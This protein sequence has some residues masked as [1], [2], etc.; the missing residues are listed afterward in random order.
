MIP[1]INTHQL[2]LR[3]F[4]PADAAPL[5]RIYRQEGV[6]R[7]FPNPE[8]PPLERV[9]RF[10]QA[11]A[12]H[13]EE[14]GYGNWAVVPRGQAEIA[15]WAGLWFISETGETEV[16]YLLGRDY[17]GKGYA[18][19]AARAAVADGFERCGL[20]QII[21]LTH[22]ENIASQRVLVKCGMRLLDQAPYW[23]MLMNRYLGRVTPRPVSQP[24]V[25]PPPA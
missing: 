15:G 17:W 2:I 4:D 24:P 20:E 8:P 1:T 14:H 12:A 7:Y 16:G 23:G 11:Q 22:P 13:W 5:Q 9:E 21:G 3:P 25:P 18:T 6:L 10:L 19:E